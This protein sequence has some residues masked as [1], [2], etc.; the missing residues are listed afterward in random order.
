[1][2]LILSATKELNNCGYLSRNLIISRLTCQPPW[3]GLDFL[4]STN[5]SNESL[6]NNH[7]NTLA[8]IP[9]SYDKLATPDEVKRAWVT[10]P[11]T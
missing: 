2:I 5:I 1:M 8:Q 7:Y 6:E 10:C 9:K 3:K 4:R 11:N